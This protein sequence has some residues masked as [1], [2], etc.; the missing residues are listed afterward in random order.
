MTYKEIT[1]RLLNKTAV[2]VDIIIAQLSEAG[3]D[4]FWEEE[5]ALK[6]YIPEENFKETLVTHCPFFTRYA[7]D[8]NWTSVTIEETNWNDLWESNFEPVYTSGCCIRAPFHKK[9][10]NIPYDIVIEPKMSFGTG[11]HETTSM[12]VEALLNLNLE[13]KSVLD[14]G[15]GTGVLAILAALR[16]ACFIDAVDND[17]W[18]YANSIEN[19]QRNN[20]TWINVL[21]GDIKSVESQTYDV[22]LANI[23][24][25]VLSEYIPQFSPM[26]NSGGVLMLSGFLTSDVSLLEK[27]AMAHG[28]VLKNTYVK[29][30]WAAMELIKK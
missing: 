27:I 18:A 3:F 29:N 2:P 11:H 6:A 21:L 13:N 1:I 30:N 7:G 22:I 16:K 28:Y 19:I 8:I 23:T 15:C 14:M 10:E 5:D 12:I 9:P 26:Q 17:N 4:G 20:V 24:R 25:N